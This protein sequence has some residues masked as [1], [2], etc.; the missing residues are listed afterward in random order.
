MNNNI[1]KKVSIKVFRN[2]LLI[3]LVI[4]GLSKSKAY[5]PIVIDILMPAPFI[6]STKERVDSF[7]KENYGKIKI[8]TT[9]GPR[10][11]ESVS[12]LA[13]SS[14]LLG[15]SDFDILLIDVTW[16]A[17]YSEAGW[18][19]PLDEFIDD[20]EWS[21]L[22]R[23]AIL[24]NSYKNIPYRW[25]LLADI[26]LLYFRKDL[27]N[28][29]PETPEEL[30]STS[31]KLINEGVVSYGYVWQ[32][33]QYEGLS[34][35]FLEA[36]HAFGGGWIDSQGKVL[37]GTKPSIK[38]ASWA[39]RL[40]ESGA[41]PRSVTNFTETEALQAFEQGEAA[42]MR[43]WPYAWA[44]LNKDNSPVKGKVGVT[45]MVAESNGRSVSTLGSWGFSILS[46]SNNKDLAYKAIKYLT[47]VQSQRHYFLNFGYTPTYKSLY[48][49]KELRSNSEILPILQQALNRTEE[50][51]KTAIYAQISEVLQKQL[52]SI[53][54]KQIT[55]KEGM[56]LAKSKTLKIIESA[57]SI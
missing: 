34:C 9:R 24:G 44:E 17:K 30:L 16:L 31:V 25:P 8:R 26:G 14:L 3:F 4:G 7:N 33:R 48:K 29:V 56:N 49:D 52:S 36:L 27:I 2:L 50:R 19:I 35:F 40:I 1:I 20:K 18:L 11:T 51:P 38:A 5:T 6:D 23:G 55:P 57:G 46:S 37:L 10:Q 42:F 15:K 53:L 28:K 45:T 39:S 32:G 54:T 12:D 43:N 13:I 21:L 22:E 47:S 41:S